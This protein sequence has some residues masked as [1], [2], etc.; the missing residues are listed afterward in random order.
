MLKH[1]PSFTLISNILFLIILLYSSTCSISCM[2]LPQSKKGTLLQLSKT[3]IKTK[4]RQLKPE[5]ICDNLFDSTDKIR[6]YIESTLQQSQ[7]NQSK[8]HFMFFTNSFDACKNINTNFKSKLFDVFANLL[9]F[10]FYCQSSIFDETKID[11]DETKV[12]VVVIKNGV[13]LENK[14]F[15]HIT[16]EYITYILDRFDLNDKIQSLLEQADQTLHAFDV[17]VDNNKNKEQKKASFIQTT[18]KRET[19][20]AIVNEHI[21]EAKGNRK[22]NRLTRFI[23][24]L[25]L[26]II[27][28]LA[29]FFIVK[30]SIDW[31]TSSR[32]ELN[33]LK[34]KKLREV[35]DL[36]LNKEFLK[37]D[38]DN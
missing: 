3:K 10:K 23:I 14:K 19:T 9:D 8:Y 6:K 25:F 13:V 11:K 29:I 32:R 21:E 35:T 22:E 37:D 17:N 33:Q 2:K 5:L 4:H 18:N 27:F 36:L 24:A 20:K 34:E 12:Q 16:D 30:Y 38:F 1:Q 7:L 26:M 15:P 31:A 28:S